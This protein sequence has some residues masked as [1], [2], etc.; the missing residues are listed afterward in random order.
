[1]LCDATPRDHVMIEGR[2]GASLDA[3]PALLH[4]A[5]LTTEGQI[6]NVVIAIGVVDV[7][8]NASVS[9][10]NVLVNKAV[11]QA[12][13]LFPDSP[14]V[15]SSI[16]PRKGKNKAV[17]ECNR[18]INEV[19][20]YMQEYAKYRSNLEYVN[21]HHIFVSSTEKM[22]KDSHGLHLSQHGMDIIV[23]N[24]VD[25]VNKRCSTPRNKRP[26]S[27]GTPPSLEKQ[28]KV[29]KKHLDPM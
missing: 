6:E 2:P 10:V 28:L 26:R 8:N 23:K 19:N 16:L 20:S 5:A 9:P 4:H 14:I 17:A 22:Y 24:I 1:M 11:D 18:K 29:L 25:F 12:S 7:M 15:L 21:H 13:V 27:A 3:V